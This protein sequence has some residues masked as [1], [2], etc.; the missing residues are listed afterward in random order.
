LLLSQQ[1]GVPAPIAGPM[2]A[3]LACYRKGSGS[4]RGGLAFA[5]DWDPQ[6]ALAVLSTGDRLAA[7]TA[8]RQHSPLTPV[9]ARVSSCHGCRF[10]GPPPGALSASASPARRPTRAAFRRRTAG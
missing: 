2:L 5:A 8:W 3:G 7:D 1:T 10:A 9:A 6:P 4:G